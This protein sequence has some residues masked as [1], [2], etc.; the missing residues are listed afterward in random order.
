MVENNKFLTLSSV[1]VLAEKLRHLA[2]RESKNSENP[3]SLIANSKEHSYFSY[4]ILG[5]DE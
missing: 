2:E 1:P 4:E 5:S 3:E